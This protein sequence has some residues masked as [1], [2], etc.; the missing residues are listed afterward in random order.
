VTTPLYHFTCDH[1]H[2]ALGACGMLESPVTHPFLGCRV[3]WLTSEALPDRET[4]GLG[5]NYTTCDRMKYRYIVLEPE[6]CHRWLGSVER[7]NAP[8]DAVADL[9]CYGDP[10]HWWI[11]DRPTKA[12][13]DD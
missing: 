12:L 13:L 1:G 8:V 9:E 7:F 11:T 3:I 10:E 5:M 2:D 4:T 6:K